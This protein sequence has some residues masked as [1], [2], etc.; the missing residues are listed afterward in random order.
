[1]IGWT[2]AIV[3]LVAIMTPRWGTLGFAI[4][5]CIPVVLGNC[6]VAVI[7]QRL[8]PEAR[9]WPRVR[10]L[11]LGGCGVAAL[12]HFALRPYATGPISFAVAVSLSAAFFLGV[13]GLFDRSA[14]A[15]LHSLV[16]RKAESV[17]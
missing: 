13:V 6:V 8:V 12:G 10:A 11:I 9:L 5:Y 2:T 3:V 14:L 15:D 16:R 1:M 7:L 4:G 17:P